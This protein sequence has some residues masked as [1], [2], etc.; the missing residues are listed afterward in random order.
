MGEREVSLSIMRYLSLA[1]VLSCFAVVTAHGPRREWVAPPSPPGVT[2]HAVN[3][4]CDGQSYTGYVALPWRRVK[5]TPGVLV[6]HTWMGLG[7]MEQYRTRQLA[8]SGYI[9]FA[10][11]VYGTGI[12][13]RTEASARGNMTKVTSDLPEYNKRLDCGFSQ[14]IK[15]ADYI[16]ASALFF[17]GY[18]FGGAMALHTAR[19]GVPKLIGVSS[20]HG[21]LENLTSQSADN[22][23]AAI[24]V[25]HADGDFA[26][27][28]GLLFLKMKCEAKKWRGGQ[29]S[30]MGTVCMAGPTPQ[31]RHTGH[32]KPGQHT[33]QC[34]ISTACS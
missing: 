6:G 2:G 9:A 24:Q 32:L 14:L 8:G 34:S 21:E 3:Y 20:F 13:P 10:L 31:R 7:A 12:R 23:T 25:H 33:T 19:R 16:N 15:A 30:S 17:N 5:G 1:I 11:D 18:C 27:A 28:Q 22:I 26:G 4:Q 29:P